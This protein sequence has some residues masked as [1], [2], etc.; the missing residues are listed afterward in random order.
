MI[1]CSSPGRVTSWPPTRRNVQIA[2]SAVRDAAPLATTNRAKTRQSRRSGLRG[3]RVSALGGNVSRL[4]QDG[5]VFGAEDFGGETHR[6]VDL[7][8]TE[9]APAGACLAQTVQQRRHSG[10][11][12]MLKLRMNAQRRLVDGKL[13]GIG[14]ASVDQIDQS[15]DLDHFV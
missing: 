12:I 6:R 2:T 1:L 11:E 14:A 13:A 5:G 7:G 3:L 15:L 8:L 9:S 4:D 10:V